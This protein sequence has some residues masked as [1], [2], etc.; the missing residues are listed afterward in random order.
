MPVMY[1]VQDVPCYECIC[2]P[3]CRMKS[4]NKLLYDC[5]T[6][7]V[8]YYSYQKKTDQTAFNNKVE[9]MQNALKGPVWKRL[10][11][12]IDEKIEKIKNGEF[13]L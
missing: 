6:L 7:R 4:F 3:T 12:E 5:D 13:E 8:F 10:L 1:K 11:T 2:V 9:V